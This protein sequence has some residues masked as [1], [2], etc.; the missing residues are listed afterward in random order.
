MEIAIIGAHRVGKSTLAEKLHEH[1]PHYD[2]HKEPY[3]EMEACGYLFPEIPGVDDFIKQFDFSIKQIAGCGDNV[4]LERCPIDIL[5]YI[6][7]LDRNMDIGQLFRTVQKVTAEIDLL[8]FVPIEEPDIIGCQRSDLP[9]L[10]KRVNEI[11][12]DWIWDLGIDTIEVHG[13]LRVRV[14]Q[15]LARGL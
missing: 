7:A 5:A 11:L 12:N 1:L 9:G 3:Y 15:V 4:I 14:N 8:V 10:R 6:H 2:L 13:D